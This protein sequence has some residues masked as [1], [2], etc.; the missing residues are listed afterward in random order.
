MRYRFAAGIALLVGVGIAAP[1]FARTR[2]IAQVRVSSQRPGSHL[3]M[4]RLRDALNLNASSDTR[5]GDTTDVISPSVLRVDLTASDLKFVSRTDQPVHVEAVM[6]PST[7]RRLSGTGH[8]V[9]LM[10][11]GHG[12]RTGE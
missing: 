12:I 9:T 4:V 11:G 5:A 8:S 6:L 3:K 10:R 2:V 1:L 7:A